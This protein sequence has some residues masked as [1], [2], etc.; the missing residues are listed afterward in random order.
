[1]HN[2]KVLYRDLKAENLLIFGDGYVKLSDFGLSKLLNQDD[3]LSKT[4]A[5]TALYNSPEMVLQMGY[6]KCADFW[7]LGV[8]LYEL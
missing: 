4:H 1:M 5:G 6:N 7:A 2:Q 3:E 8:L